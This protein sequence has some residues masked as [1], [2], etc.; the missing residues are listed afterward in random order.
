MQRKGLFGLLIIG[1]LLLLGQGCYL[2]EKKE[3]ANY[4]F[5]PTKDRIKIPGTAFD[6][7][8]L[9]CDFEAEFQWADLLAEINGDEMVFRKGLYATHELYPAHHA[10]LSVALWHQVKGDLEVEFRSNL[11]FVYEREGK[12]VGIIFVD[13]DQYAVSSADGQQ[14]HLTREAMERIESI[15]LELRHPENFRQKNP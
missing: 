8:V 1:A 14:I 13:L 11:T 10:D 7:V 9:Y 4:E 6:K 12:P 5:I 15:Y 3:E 2:L